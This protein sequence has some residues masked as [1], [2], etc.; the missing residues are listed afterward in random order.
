MFGKLFKTTFTH[1]K[2]ELRDWIVN[3]PE[4]PPRDRLFKIV[5]TLSKQP[6]Y[7]YLLQM[8]KASAK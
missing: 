3:L 8:S 5:C 4:S 1:Q 7:V 6:L 2:I